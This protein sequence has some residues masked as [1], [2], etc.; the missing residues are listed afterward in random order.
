MRLR[1]NKTGCLGRSDAW[2]APGAEG[3]AGRVTVIYQQPGFAEA[4]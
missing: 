1:A 3:H 4:I 2:K